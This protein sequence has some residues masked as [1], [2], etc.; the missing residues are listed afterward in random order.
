MVCQ[1]LQGLKIGNGMIQPITVRE[2][3]SGYEIIAGE[4]RFR[5]CRMAGMTQIPCYILSPSDEQAAEMALVENVQR[6]D[7]TAIEEAKAYV[8][9]M[10]QANLT[11]QEAAKK[12][13]KSQ[14]AV[15]N[16]IRLLNLPQEV[17]DAVAERKITE[18]H[19]R[20]LLAIEAKEEQYNL[21]TRIFDEKLSVR[22]VEAII[23]QIKNPKVPKAFLHLHPSGNFLRRLH[24]LLTPIRGFLLQKYVLQMVH[25]HP[26]MHEPSEWYAAPALIHLQL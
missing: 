10:R 12:T 2:T 5:A 14:S 11:Q 24:G 8:Q 7:L 3:E 26:L 17:Q 1:K 20:A 13:G 21:A 22:E 16:K 6:E 4:R 23:R 25:F 9:I 15:A 19:A 18:R